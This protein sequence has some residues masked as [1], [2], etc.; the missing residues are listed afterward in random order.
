[1]QTTSVAEAR[2]KLAQ[3]LQAVEQGEEVVIRRY[4]KPVARLIPYESV[5]TVFPDLSDFRS[6]QSN[7]TTSLADLRNEERY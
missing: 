4:S 5:E 2:E 3:L 6:K 1:M 7:A